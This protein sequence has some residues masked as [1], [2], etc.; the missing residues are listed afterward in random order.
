MK[1]LEQYQNELGVD[2][3]LTLTELI[4]S[5]RHQRE[6]MQDYGK[7]IAEAYNRGFNNGL[8]SAIVD[9]KSPDE[10]SQM[11]VAELAKYINE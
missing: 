10:L 2:Y 5:H 9:Y 11:T 7:N 1:E 8:K 6:I 3:T 4:K